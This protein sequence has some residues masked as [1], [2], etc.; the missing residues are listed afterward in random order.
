MSAKS[1]RID[2]LIP[3]DEYARERSIHDSEFAD[4]TRNRAIGLLNGSQ[5]DRRIAYRILY[6]QLNMSQKEVCEFAQLQDFLRD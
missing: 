4:A 3:H 5:E 1:A 2:G 6:R